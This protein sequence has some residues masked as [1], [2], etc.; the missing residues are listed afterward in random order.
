VHFA[1]FIPLTDSTL[2]F[3][4][5]F[6]GS[7]IDYA[8]GFIKHLGPLFDQLLPH[9][10]D[11]P[12]TPVASNADA[13]ISWMEE[14]DKRSLG[15]YSAYPTMEVKQIRS[16]AGLTGPSADKG[17]QNVLAQIFPLKSLLDFMELRFLLPRLMPSMTKSSDEIG[18][19]HFADFVDLGKGHIGFFT[20]YDGDF[21]SYMNDFMKFIGP[22]FDA[23]MK[24][25]K[26]PAPIPVAKN[27]E[28]F[29][30]WAAAL[31]RDPI[32]FYSAYPTLGVQ[33]VKALVMAA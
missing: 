21:S 5:E 23:L 15:F 10:A 7:F 26:N 9:L 33:D 4:S 8:E 30:A 18:T 16:Q 32:V 24:H 20:I 28:N 29:I 13:F 27:P 2:A 12:P 17:V 25:M 11:S 6:E 3:I 19:L 1:R 31:Q 22:T 14:H